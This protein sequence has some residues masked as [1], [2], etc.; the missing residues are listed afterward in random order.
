MM[1]LG[2]LLA[3][4]LLAPSAGKPS[5]CR[6]NRDGFCTAKVVHRVL[7][8][9]ARSH[10]LRIQC[11]LGDVVSLEFPQN[12]GV[13]ADP[14][15]GNQAV[16]QVEASGDPLRVLLWPKVPSGLR[17]LSA[18][19][20]DGARSNLQVFLDS[21]LTV[22]IDLRIGPSEQA[23]QRV[24]F[25]FPERDRESRYVADRLG[26][27]SRALAAKYQDQV[28]TLTS[29]LAVQSQTLL[30]RWMLD[31]LACTDL[32]RR[33][34]RDGLV[35]QVQRLCAVGPKWLVEVTL[36]HRGRGPRFLLERLE[37]TRDEAGHEKRPSQVVWSN[38]PRLGFDEAA[39]A[40]VAFE[41]DQ[42]VEEHHLFVTE[43]GGK[44]RAVH[45]DE[46]RF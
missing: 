23:V 8:Y 22:L 46:L 33:E 14:A 17:R 1:F 35:V 18:E 31:R 44:R 7:R 9:Q 43:R 13:V 25:S 38:E 26:T 4:G 16:F 39:R 28:Q 10:R 27:L 5:E 45:V 2:I 30:A 12:V 21:G 6:P 40:I 15:V 3:A 36:L 34:E 11:A 20:L 42:Q 19:A 37:V 32:D 24:V 29:S 41:P